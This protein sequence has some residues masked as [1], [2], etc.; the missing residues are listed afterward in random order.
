MELLV[1]CMNHG[2]GV[3]DMI[4]GIR[5]VECCFEFIHVYMG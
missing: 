5:N 1:V 2:S 3:V 4:H